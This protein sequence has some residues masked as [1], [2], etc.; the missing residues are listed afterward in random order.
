MSNKAVSVCGFVF[1]FGLFIWQISQTFREVAS[2][3]DK[4]RETGSL[5]VGI[6]GVLKSPLL[7]L[8]AIGY[9]IWL[10]V[11]SRQ[12]EQPDYRNR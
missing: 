12:K 4:L 2:I 10:F 7:T 8:V 11:S 5:G 9:A 6:S 3:D 1:G